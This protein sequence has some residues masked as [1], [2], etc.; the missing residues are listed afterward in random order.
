MADAANLAAWHEVL[1]NMEHRLDDAARAMGDSASVVNGLAWAAPSS[2]GSIPAELAER[3]RDVLIN[4]RKII[5]E[6]DTAKRV[7]R[8]H[9]A[10]V[11]SV[12]PA[13]NPGTA[14][15]LDVAG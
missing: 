15:Y 4:Q 10:A 5:A 14:V 9:L 12:P 2:I 11:R 3:A 6:L 1:A 13:R 7:T 8:Q